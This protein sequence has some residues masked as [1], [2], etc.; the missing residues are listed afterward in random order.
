MG[1]RGEELDPFGGQARFQ[2]VGIMQHS[3]TIG[4]DTNAPPVGCLQAGHTDTEQNF[5]AAILFNQILNHPGAGFH[6]NPFLLFLGGSWPDIAGI[7]LR[8]LIG[9]GNRAEIA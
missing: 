8:Q 1:N 9:N 6:I 7:P 2:P 3:G 4:D 5:F